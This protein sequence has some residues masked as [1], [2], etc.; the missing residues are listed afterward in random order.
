VEEEEGKGKRKE[1]IKRKRHTE[2]QD[3]E[4]ARHLIMTWDKIRAYVRCS[5]GRD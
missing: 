1:K 3:R 2:D 5:R 4:L